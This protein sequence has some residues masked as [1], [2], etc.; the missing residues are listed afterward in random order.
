MG[1]I[2]G[3]NA[4]N[5]QDPVAFPKKVFYTGSDAVVAGY[6]CC[7]DRDYGTATD[8]D[9]KRDARVAL[10]DNTNN[11]SFAGV[12]AKSYA[13][14]TGGQWV[15]IYVPGSICQIYVDAS[16][17][18]SETNYLTCQ[19]GGGGSGTF[20]VGSAGGLMGRGTARIMQTRTGAGLVLAELI[21]GQESGL[22]ET[23]TPVDNTAVPMMVGGV[24]LITGGITLGTGNSTA[25][26]AN[27]THVGQRKRIECL[28]T[29][30]T[31]DYVVSATS[32]NITAQATSPADTSL[33]VADVT[34]MA[35]ASISF[36]A[37]NENAYLEWSGKIWVLR[38]YSGAT[39]A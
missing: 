20:D 24:T 23:I 17:T 18:I 39:L 4:S 25:S 36:D 32:S 7:Y 21:D 33:T 38:A 5:Y 14:K 19:I 37:A 9:G 35:I 3:A 1:S 34:N 29:L 12:F 2:G 6:G 30:T 8:N 26:L 27:G 15:T 11:N 31:N 22:V 16:T 28:G 13:A 10:P